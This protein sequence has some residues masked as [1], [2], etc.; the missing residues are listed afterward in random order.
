MKKK[1][2]AGLL[3]TSL[4]IPVIGGEILP[5]SVYAA[6]A[7][8]GVT[9]DKPSLNL[10]VGDTAS[11][12]LTSPQSGTAWN[13]SSSDESVARVD[14]LTGVVTGVTPGIATI[15]VSSSQGSAYCNVFVEG[16]IQ[17][18]IGSNTGPSSINVGA[19]S[20]K[21]DA[22]MAGTTIDN[23]NLVWHSS[24]DNKLLVNQNGVITAISP[25][26]VIITATTQLGTPYFYTV[27]VLPPAV[28]PTPTPTPTPT[29]SNPGTGGG[30]N[31]RGTSKA[32]NFS[33]DQKT[34]NSVNFSW[35]GTTGSVLVELRTRSGSPVNSYSTSEQRASFSGLSSNTDYTIYV[36]G[37]QFDTFTTRPYNYGYGSYYNGDTYYNGDPNSNGGPYNGGTYYNGSG[38][39]NTYIYNFSVDRNS[40]TS[41]DFSWDGTSGSVSVELR[42]RSDNSF[43]GS[44]STSNRSATFSGLSNGTEY[45]VYINGQY[46]NSFISG[47]SSSSTIWNFSVT[48]RT[49]SSAAVS[50]SGTTG[51]VRVELKRRSDGSSVDAN[52]TGSRYI[53]FNGL[54]PNTDYSVYIDGNYAGYFT[55]NYSSSGSDGTVTGFS[56]DRKNLTSVSFSWSQPSYYT[57]VE[58]RR[59]GSRVDS[60][61]SVSRSGTFSSLA[62]DT[63]YEIYIGG[64][65]AGSFRTDKDNS[66]SN[67]HNPGSAITFSDIQYHWARSAIENLAQRNIVTGYSDGTFRPNDTVTREQYVTMLV[68]T[69]G[70]AL[71]GD[72]VFGD[73][74]STSW[75]APYIGAAIKNGIV[76]PSEYA[77]SFRPQKAITREEMAVLAA[78]AMRLSPDPGYLT[79]ND[80]YAVSDKGLV[81]AAARAGVVSG[82]P[83]HSFRPGNFV[84][85]AAAA[86][87]VNRVY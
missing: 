10:K 30:V 65:Y 78:R 37:Q 58:L 28:S 16:P 82:Y 24:D 36:D 4:L 11:I 21:I 46:V 61:S 12:Q 56:I 3:V 81:G 63:S 15:V 52:Y 47:G 9:I 29:P 14:T 18:K 20:Q 66:S 43:I 84:T 17:L 49:D 40:G 69:K 67:V 22:Y 53:T 45:S 74:S 83:D 2:V 48:N 80:T 77:G 86:V 71:G 85:R 35:S 38:Y 76:I 19:S 32:V 72:S 70:Y 1:I 55:T 60:L 87:V 62:A 25:G 59:N 64:R 68:Q 44:S 8:S 27:N 79:F 31:G 73:L 34:S 26:T 33:I 7:S 57:Q 54:V 51:N 6:S 13:W 5:S 41:V 42:R 23:S 75:S 39:T 50:W